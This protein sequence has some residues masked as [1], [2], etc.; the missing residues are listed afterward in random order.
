[1]ATGRTTNNNADDDDDDDDAR[2]HPASRERLVL[3]EGT[4]EQIECFGYRR[5]VPRTIAFSIVGVLTLGFLFLVFRWKPNWEIKLMYERCSLAE[6]DVLLVR[7][8]HQRWHTA[9]VRN[10]PI[11]LPSEKRR[12]REDYCINGSPS[13]KVTVENSDVGEKVEFVPNDMTSDRNKNF[14]V[15]E[16]ELLRFFHFQK[17]MYIWDREIALFYRLGGLEE[18]VPCADFYRTFTGFSEKEQ[19]QRRQIYGRN[20]IFVELKTIPVLIFQEALNPFYVFQ[21][22]SVCLW[23]FGYNYIIFSVAIVVM[24]LIS[25]MATVYNTRKQATTLRKMVRSEGKVRVLRAKDNVDDDSVFELIR[26]TDLV[27][28]DV[29]QLPLRGSQ[30]SCD[31]VLI[32]GNCIV[33][34]S[35]L[36]GESV[37]I[38]KT[39]LPNPPIPLDSPPMMFNPENHKRH[40]LFCG[41]QVIQSRRIGKKSVLAVVIRTGFTTTKGMLVRSILYPKPMDFKLYRD[42]MKFILVLAAV[43]MFGFV[44]VITIKILHKAT[45]KDIILKALDVFTIAVSPALPAALTIGM[46]FAQQRLRKRNI[47]CISPQRINVSGMLD[48]ICFD[49]TGTL[50]E[51]HLELLAVSPINKDSFVLINDPSTLTFGPF[52]AGMAT[53]HSLTVIDGEIRGDPLDLQMFQSIKWNL[54]EPTESERTGFSHFMPTIVMD[55]SNGNNNDSPRKG[56]M[57][58]L[59]AHQIGVIRQFT[60]SSNLKRM[61]VITQT[62]GSNTFDV[63]VKGAPEIV[64]SL[65]LEESIPDNFNDALKEHTMNGL[66]VLA[67]AWKPLAQNVT[68]EQAQGLERNDIECDLQL[69]GLLIMQNTLK[70]ETP[71]VIEEL[72]NANIRTVMVTGDNILTAIHVAR[73]CGMIGPSEL[74]VEVNVTPPSRDNKTKVTYTL[75]DVVNACSRQP[76][77]SHE[78]S[79]KNQEEVALT[80]E[81]FHGNSDGSTYHFALDGKTFLALQEYTPHLIPKIAVK[82]TIFA[83][84]SPDQKAQLVEVFQDMEYYVGMCG[85]GAND[86]GALKRAHAGISLSEAEASVASPFTSRT[87]NVECVSRLIK[88]GRAA[89]VASFGVFKYMA[90]YSMIQFTSVIIMNTIDSFPSDFMFMYWDIAI[91]TIVALLVARNHAYPSIVAKKPLTSLMDPALLFSVLTNTVLQFGVQIAGY[92]LLTMQPWF[93]PLVKDRDDISNSYCYEATSIFFLS[94]FQ[95]IIVAFLFSKGPPFRKPI[96]TNVLFFVSLVLLTIYTVSMMFFPIQAVNNY[97]ELM[98]LE[99][100]YYFVILGLAVVHF[101]LALLLESVL[102]DTRFV[103]QYGTCRKLRGKN[104]AKK[105]D[106]MIE[107]I[108]NDNIWPPITRPDSKIPGFKRIDMGAGNLQRNTTDL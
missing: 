104:R 83:R 7:D 6:A 87:Q 97:G 47:Y 82:A 41:T 39:P 95:Y 103:R 94:S 35:M 13:V 67:M 29:I 4:D 3:G 78:F 71:P 105:Y 61:S 9:P 90:L 64:A 48:L 10:E 30:M 86:C 15:I 5:N 93:T 18:N 44:Y 98:E 17:V 33:N 1:M 51:D 89:L 50:T 91:T 27:P 34:E 28:G 45:V 58:V 8:V 76:S 74:V 20:E 26:E 100:Y 38:T 14:K 108:N 54:K 85:D 106:L 96:Y 31:A 69:L 102:A 73:Q 77:P 12:R 60:F 16:Q 2:E 75:N 59:P 62:L 42:A 80:L 84:M 68:Y 32:S 88:E 81:D 57:P 70:P 52:T 19:Q 43:A 37:P 40:T 72:N 107:E 53:C 56:M 22:Y 55:T 63:F 46:V 23:I 65:C 101:A 24:S 11:E 99:T 36:T 21:I 49:K 25:I 66:R 79:S 92:F